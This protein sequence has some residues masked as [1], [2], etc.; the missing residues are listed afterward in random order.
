MT[1]EVSDSSDK[2]FLIS[3]TVFVPH[4]AMSEGTLIA[5]AVD[6]IVMDENAVLGSVDPQLGQQPAASIVKVL[7]RK[8]IHE[9]DDTT[10]IL[11]DI[12]EKA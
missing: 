8:P 3:S 4:Y 11:A 9:I 1:A 12:G 5:L 2:A 6:E 7:E 10:I